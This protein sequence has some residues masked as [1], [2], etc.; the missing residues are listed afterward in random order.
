[1]NDKQKEKL[2]SYKLLKK[3]LSLVEKIYND[4][5]TDKNYHNYILVFLQIEPLFTP[6][7]SD[8]LKIKVAYNKSDIN[9]IHNFIIVSKN[10]IGVVLN[11]YK[12]SKFFGRIM[13]QF[14]P[15][16]AKVIRDYLTHF[17]NPTV[18]FNY[19]RQSM[20]K[21]LNKLIGVSNQFI[22][23]IKNDYVIKSKSF[24]NLSV[25]QKKTRLI[26]LFQHSLN[27]GESTYRKIDLVNN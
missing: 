24:Q 7:A 27:E 4:N 12:T 23:T 25:E 16:E 14:K 8:Y 17:N 9:D 11:K 19:N 6:R 26:T 22:R 1:M 10:K 20:H 18:L 3:K 5:P 21:K 15:S 13:I 2:I